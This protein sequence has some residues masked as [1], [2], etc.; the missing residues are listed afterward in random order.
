M[1]Y[2][3]ETALNAFSCTSRK[4]KARCLPSSRLAPASIPVS[5][6]TGWWCWKR[7]P[8]LR[9]C[10]GCG[11]GWWS[12]SRETSAIRDQC[13]R[14]AIVGTCHSRSVWCDI[15]V[16]GMRIASSLTSAMLVL[17]TIRMAAQEQA[18]AAAQVRRLE[19]KWAESYKER[20]IDILSTLL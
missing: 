16:M 11:R 13:G 8:L 6:R 10:A 2:S 14:R 18:G 1:P 12:D 19:E 15:E 4:K 17:L 9:C 7:K 5:I 20:D 3:K